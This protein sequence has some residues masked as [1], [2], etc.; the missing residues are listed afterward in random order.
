MDPVLGMALFA[1]IFGDKQGGQAPPPPNVGPNLPPP[2][3]NPP[4]II[5]VGP[6]TTPN[7]PNVQPPNVQ[8]PNVTPPN[9][10]ATPPAWIAALPFPGGWVPASGAVLTPAIVQKA[11][12]LLG[13]T[14]FRNSD[15]SWAAAPP[16]ARRLLLA[17]G[18]WTMFVATGP[19]PSANVVALVPN[20]A[21]AP[22]DTSPK[23]D[24]ASTPAHTET[25]DAPQLHQ[26]HAAAPEGA[27]A[28]PAGVWSAFV[29]GNA[30]AIHEWA[31]ETSAD[32]SRATEARDE[33]EK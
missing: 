33:K 21:Y 23:A 12:D 6:N 7:N 27:H 31:R 8:P 18:Q 9:W 29:Q 15:P 32:K 14:T 5:P 28:I 30:N 26:P 1:L 17:G 24:S 20:P 25:S 13:D 4:V 22:A 19:A 11:H 10:P 3:V 16:N 2:N